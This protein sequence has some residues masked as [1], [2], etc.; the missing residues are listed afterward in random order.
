[1]RTFLSS[2]FSNDTSKNTNNNS[3]NDGVICFLGI[4]YEPN[5]TVPFF[6]LPSLPFSLKNRPNTTNEYKGTTYPPKQYKF[7]VRQL[8]FLIIF[9]IHRIEK[10]FR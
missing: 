2:G 8:S 9:G 5:Q 4:K 1:M 7:N 3:R 6:F 10:L